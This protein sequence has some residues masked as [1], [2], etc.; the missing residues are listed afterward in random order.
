VQLEWSSMRQQLAAVK[1]QL[2]EAR[3]ANST[4]GGGGGAAARDDE[5][6]APPVRAAKKSFGPTTADVGGASSAIKLIKA[7]GSAS[8]K[9]AAF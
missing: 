5:P 7:K 1:E 3:K 2:N 8:S 4:G 6:A 9:R